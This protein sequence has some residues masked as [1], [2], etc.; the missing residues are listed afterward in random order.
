M[1]LQARS[2]QNKALSEE[3]GTMARGIATGVGGVDM[4]LVTYFIGKRSK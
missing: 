4:R 3:S 2:K 1:E